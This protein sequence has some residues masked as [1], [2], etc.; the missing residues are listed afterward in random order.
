MLQLLHQ[1]K[2]KLIQRIFIY[3]YWFTNNFPSSIAVLV[4]NQYEIPHSITE[5]MGFTPG[6]GRRPGHGQCEC[7]ITLHLNMYPRM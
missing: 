3:S 5:P 6:A 7:M 2:I 4:S 1:L